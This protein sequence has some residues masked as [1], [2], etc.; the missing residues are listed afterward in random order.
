[1]FSVLVITYPLGNYPPPITGGPLGINAV[2]MGDSIRFS[3]MI[4]NTVTGGT[5]VSVSPVYS[6]TC[7]SGALPVDSNYFVSMRCLVNV[8]EYS[9]ASDDD[10]GL[11][12][13]Q[14][15]IQ[16]SSGANTN[17]VSTLICIES[18][19]VFGDLCY[20]GVGGVK[21]NSNL[22]RSAMYVYDK[23]VYSIYQI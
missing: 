6:I 13:H 5:T 10:V 21:T 9:E 17:L 22:D 2:A 16:R 8:L 3:R 15:Q 19:N 4:P 14:M 18:A 11:G 12:P 7:N 23:N 20:E 1:M